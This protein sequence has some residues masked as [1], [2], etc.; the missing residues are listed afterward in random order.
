[1]LG[2]VSAEQLA[3]LYHKADAFVLASRFEGYG[4]AYAEALSRGLPIVGTT[5][6]AISQT[7]PDGAGLL[8]TAGDEVAL[9]NALRAVINDAALRSRISR[10]A[11]AAV[12]MLPTWRASGAA[13]AR[14]LERLR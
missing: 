1:M 5:A 10:A 8:V 11:L 14:V 6:G 3:E 7:V 2:A 9:A 4:M 12:A 13:F